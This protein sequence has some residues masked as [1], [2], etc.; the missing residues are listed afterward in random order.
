M[1]FNTVLFLFSLICFSISAFAQTGSVR[2]TVID[3]AGAPVAGATV[4]LREKSTRAERSVTTNASGEFSF[5]SGCVTTCDVIVKANGFGT[6]TVDAAASAT[7]LAI[8]I[9]PQPLKEEV[10]VT[11][12]RAELLTTETAVPVSV[13]DREEIDRKA[14]NTIGDIFRTLP[15]TSTA[16]E[17]AFQVRPR[18]RGLD[19]NRV[20]ILVDGERLNNSRTSTGQSGI[21][22][23]LV[24]TSQIETV[25][26]LRGS[27][28]V[29]YGTDALAGTINI[30]TRDTPPRGDTSS[31]RFGGAFD[32]FYSSNENGRRGNLAL[33]GANKFFAFRVAQSMDRF[34]NYSAG[35]ATDAEKEDLRGQD[36][37][38]TDDNEILNSQSHSSNSQATLRFFLND[39]NT[40]KFNYERRRA[41][42][43]GSAGLAGANTGLPELVGV[44]NAFFPF[45]NRDKFSVRYDVAA[46]T[47]NLQRISV[48]AFYQTQYRSFTNI[49]TVPAVQPFFP[50]LYQL[51][52]TVTDTKTA[53]LDL[54]SD[55]IFGRHS[56]VA[57]ASWFRDTNSDRR[58]VV[59]STNSYSPN[60]TFRNSRSV[61]DATLSNLAFFA[62]DDFRVTKRLRFVGGIR[63]DRFS[64][65]SK[66]TDE[67]ALDP[68]LNAHQI[69]VLGLNG[70][71]DGLDIPYT[72]LTGDFGAVYAV[73]QYLNLSARIGRSFRT[74]NIAER[75][76]TDPGS[77]EGFLVGNPSLVPETGINFDT[78]AK[79]HTSR[80]NFA[81]TYFN[82]YFENFLATVAAYDYTDPN[83]PVPIQILT[84]GRPPTQVY[85]TQNIRTARIQGF[86]T[87]IEMPFK[88]RLG[89]LTPYGNFSYLHGEDLNEHVPLDAISPFRTNVGFRWQNFGKSYFVDYNVRFVPSYAAANDIEFEPGF[90]SHNIG[91]GYYMRRERFN[92]SVNLGVS[93]IMNKFYSEQFVFAPARGRSFTIGT[94][95]EIK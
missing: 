62:Q 77:A 46:L 67:F 5:E 92:F 54:Q 88:I 61:P 80:V 65:V 26:V 76:F 82:N 72:S 7:P 3:S 58:L 23:G 75:F 6:A 28:S 11:A 40:L 29:L 90:V 73:T 78:S 12:G 68:R 87:E 27:G 94:S 56:V 33:T 34:D 49:L 71:G 35:N 4:M 36:L 79:V 25:E 86:E 24:E 84:P 32:T 43:I 15:G 42:N 2:G 22:P 30:I 21:E 74:P 17:G 57:G 45:N 19:S 38:I 91:G 64:T 83:N 37:M 93:N 48:K 31:F 70:I 47:E 52:D 14:V 20:L 1:K 89:Y 44:F 50:G 59:S 81:A 60:R 13:V 16:N 85:Q 18:I 41:G 63:V 66:P 8:T 9:E 51:S 39:T 55:W 53:G 10:T 95:I 69:D